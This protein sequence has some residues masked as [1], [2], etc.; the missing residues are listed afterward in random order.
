MNILFVWT[1][2]TSYMPDCWR[3]LIRQSNVR[4][5]VVIET[6]RNP[7]QTAFCAKEL[8]AGLD[9]SLCFDDEAIDRDYWID[10]I[11]SFQ[12]DI[13]YLVGWHAH[14]PRFFATEKSWVKI[15]KILIFDLPFQWGIRKFLAPLVLHAYLKHFCGAFVPGRR[16]MSYAHWL[17]FHR[18]Q[19]GL[20]SIRLPECISVQ[21]T[22]GFLF[23]GRFSREKRLDILVSAYRLYREKIRD[24]VPGLSPWSLTCCGKGEEE[25]CLQNQEGIEV[26]G[27]CMPDEV[28]A[29]YVTKRALVLCSDFD[30][31]PLVIL[32]AVSHGMPVICTSACGDSDELIRGNGIVCRPRNVQEIAEAMVTM[33]LNADEW[34]TRG[35]AGRRLSEPYGCEA[36]SKRVLA[37]SSDVIGSVMR[38]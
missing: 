19:K 26:L 33:H 1:G 6:K 24:R 16:A 35:M 21:R 25:H 38:T 34:Q 17:G 36:W 18:I 30:P 23:V 32:E 5:K 9:V 29:L 15:P 7:T 2:V 22:E 31:W 37:L 11:H 13:M 3:A 4:L 12:P 14:V 27:F 20:F 10:Q 8:L 28:R